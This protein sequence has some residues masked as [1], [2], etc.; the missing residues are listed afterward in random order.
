MAIL[1]L[2]ERQWL[3]AANRLL[4]L[5]QQLMDT[6][7]SHGHIAY[8]HAWATVLSPF[9]VGLHAMVACLASMDR[10]TFRERLLSNRSFAASHLNHP[11][12]AELKGLV[13]AVLGDNRFD[14]TLPLLRHLK[15][16]LSLDPFLCPHCNELLSVI[17]DKLLGLYLQ[18]FKAVSLT[19]MADDLRV[20]G[21]ELRSTV[22]KL[23][24]SGK[25]NAKL[26]FSKDLLLRRASASLDGGEAASS[27]GSSSSSQLQRQA[28]LIQQ[29]AAGLKRSLLLLSLRKHGLIVEGSKEGGIGA[30]MLQQ[31]GGLGGAGGMR[32][33]RGGR[34]S[35]EQRRERGER[36]GG[37]NS[38]PVMVYSDDEEG[39]D[40]Q[41]EDIMGGGGGYMS[42]SAMMAG[43]Y[44]E[45]QIAMAMSASLHQ[46]QEQMQLMMAG[47]DEDQTAAEDEGEDHDM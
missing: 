43:N 36:A 25:V 22:V 13:Q 34:G 11:L 21:E 33:M 27:S 8:D 31:L 17:E 40:D 46:H 3:S 14:Q 38:N 44:E 19:R 26:D 28:R 6:A 47:D 7:G 35:R 12:A 39:T 41:E 16:R 42:S 1:A 23:V 15:S 37:N 20:D 24:S 2:R 10:A 5:D 18:P 32:R 29:A 9:D 45:Q 30:G 4:E